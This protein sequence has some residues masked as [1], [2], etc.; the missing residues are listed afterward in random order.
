MEQISFEQM[1]KERFNN[2]TSGQKKVAEYLIQQLE[3][4]AFSKEVQIGLKTEATEATVIRFSNALGF[5]G[6]THMQEQ[7]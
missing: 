2:L 4:A 5:K 7:I 1:V 6:F 3:E